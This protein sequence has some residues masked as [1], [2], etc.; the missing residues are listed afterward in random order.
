MVQSTIEYLVVQIANVFL[1][2]GYN[3]RSIHE[4]EV[5]MRKIRFLFYQKT[6]DDIAQ[7]HEKS[8]LDL[9]HRSI[10]L[11]LAPYYETM[12]VLIRTY[13]GWNE[14]EKFQMAGWKRRCFF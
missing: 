10:S 2:N 13:E 1:K 11:N 8:T 3:H 12:L 9:Y 6:R 14:K 4:K 7:F 5:V